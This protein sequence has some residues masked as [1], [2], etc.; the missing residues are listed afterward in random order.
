GPG[1][2][3]LRRRRPR[4][5]RLAHGLHRHHALLEPAGVRRRR[6]RRRRAR[7]RARVHQVGHRLLHQGAHQARRALGRGRRRRHGPLLLAAAGGHDDVAAGVQGGPRPARVRRRRRDRG[8]HGRRV[9]GVPGAQPALRQPPPPPRAAAVRVR[10][11]V[12]GQVRQQ[13]R[14]GEELLRLRQRL[15]RRAPLGRALAPP[16]HR[17]RRVPGLRR[18]QRRRLRRHRLGHH[19]VQLGRQVRRRPDPRR[20]A[21]AQRGALAAAQGDAGAVQGEG[22]ALRVRVPGQERRGRQ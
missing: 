5:V 8:R 3:V 10:R 21:A 16:R 4:Q 19:R 6:R 22:G 17:T 11:Q 18:R 7:P 15:P 12:P 2:R 13:H 1:G 14:G 9:H 20:K